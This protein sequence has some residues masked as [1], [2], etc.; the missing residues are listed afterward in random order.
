[1]SLPT[2]SVAVCNLALDLL[3]QPPISNIDT[4]V[5]QA[6]AICARWYDLIRQAV[7]S[8]Y[9]WQFA[10]VGGALSRAGTPA[11]G[12]YVDYYAFPIDYLKLLAIHDR[13]VP[14]GRYDYKI[15]GKYIHLDNG[16]A[17]TLTAWWLQDV[18]DVPRFPPVFTNL[19]VGELAMTLAPKIA[20]KRDVKAEA[21]DFADHWRLKALAFNGQTQPPRR[22]ESS[23]VVNAGRYPS[24]SQQVAGD[25]EFDSS[26]S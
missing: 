25:Y 13:D 20:K 7:L 3:R 12:A 5:S 6:E 16:G 14:L 2:S 19:L 22:Y 4:P 18:A 11:Y 24:H 9:N 23:R 1:M 15:E 26:F 21:K 8:A 10:T 17:A